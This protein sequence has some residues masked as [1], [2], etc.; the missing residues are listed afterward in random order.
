M[1]V[2]ETLVGYLLTS[3]LEELE[4]IPSGIKIG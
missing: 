4:N 1:C 3:S 2:W